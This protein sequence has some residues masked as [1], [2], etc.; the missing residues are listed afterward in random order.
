MG[1]IVKFDRLSRGFPDVFP[2]MVFGYP[3]F[4]GLDPVHGMG[5]D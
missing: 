5:P 2:Q 4:P 3:N 1:S